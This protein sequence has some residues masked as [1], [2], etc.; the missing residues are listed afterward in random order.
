M[1][2]TSRVHCTR[3]SSHG[4]IGS[5][6]APV[7]R[8]PA[9]WAAGDG[10]GALGAGAL[11]AAAGAFPVSTFRSRSTVIA[12]SAAPCM[13]NLVGTVL[14][15]ELTNLVVLLRPAPIRIWRRELGSWGMA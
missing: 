14:T 2:V 13:T 11:G 10:A 12:K 15:V 5:D 4:L 8:A 7:P 9:G 6:A 1:V 3:A